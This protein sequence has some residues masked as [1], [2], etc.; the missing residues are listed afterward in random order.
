MPDYE[1]IGERQVVERTGRGWD[2][3]F[4][5]L[6]VFDRE[7]EERREYH[8]RA[9]HLREEYRLDPWWAR[10]VA[11]RYGREHASERE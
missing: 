7:H 10:A 5:V 11:V 9:R 1:S 3:W 6:S 4:R 8:E 2:E